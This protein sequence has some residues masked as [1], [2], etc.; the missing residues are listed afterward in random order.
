VA[1]VI[2]RT[3]RNPV[4]PVGRKDYRLERVDRDYGR[5][6]RLTPGITGGAKRRLRSVATTIRA[7]A[8]AFAPNRAVDA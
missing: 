3:P 7:A 6:S 2:P 8:Q 4:I 1:L 5:E